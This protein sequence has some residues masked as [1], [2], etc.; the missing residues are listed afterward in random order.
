[1]PIV[2][3]PPHEVSS[4]YIEDFNVFR[5]GVIAC[6]AQTEFLFGRLA[7]K[8]TPA[9]DFEPRQPSPPWTVEARMDRIIHTFETA[10][11]IAP[12]R[13]QAV[14]LAKRLSVLT[15]LRNFLAHGFAKLHPKDLVW[16]I[17]RFETATDA[18]WSEVE[19]RLHLLDLSPLRAEIGA[20]A[21]DAF[22]FVDR[23]NETYDLGM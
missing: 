23:L 22:E 11:E 8:L 12:V 15:D 10:P 16:S 4:V 18:P 9:L 17:S 3:T 21:R 6:F 2:D 14:G 13:D 1:M 7:S 20:L 5:G 19:L